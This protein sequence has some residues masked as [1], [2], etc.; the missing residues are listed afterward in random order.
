M[1]ALII[2]AI[3]ALTGLAVYEA[4]AHD[5]GILSDDYIISQ[6]FVKAKVIRVRPKERTV[7]VR[8]V[9][10]G[11]T[12]DFIIS[13]GARIMIQGRDARLRD[14]RP[15][16]VIMLSI[17]VQDEDALISRIRVPETKLDLESRRLNPVV[18]DPGQT[19]P[20]KT[21]MQ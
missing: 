8:G 4:A 21:Q 13:E 9:V 2:L 12:R 7:T 18:T 3:V 6:E 20:S 17:V 5:N 19:D 10:R 15:G 16:D 11:Q 1:R 14:L